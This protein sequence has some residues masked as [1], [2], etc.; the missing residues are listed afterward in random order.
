MAMNSP[1]IEKY[2]A[3][4]KEI[5][6]R[7]EVIVALSSGRANC[8]YIPSTIESI[9]LQFRKCFEHI[10]FASLAA[11]RQQYESAY[12]DFAKHWEASK[13]V[14]NLKKINPDFYPKPVVE[15]PSDHPLARH[16]L[17]DRT[18]DFL[19][20]RDLIEAHGRCGALLHSANP[21]GTPIDYEFYRRAFQGWLLKMTNL[22]NNHQIRLAGEKGFFL[23]HM[24]EEGHD[25][26]RW[27]RLGDPP[28]NS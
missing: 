15:K 14:K 26:V 24:K 6:L 4:M 18:G 2:A 28:Q 8:V 3:V 1:D 19:T 23:V 16:A 5:K 20:E 21:F 10:A 25:E 17:A 11:N 12:A 27:Y 13:L 22:L 9:G 7:V